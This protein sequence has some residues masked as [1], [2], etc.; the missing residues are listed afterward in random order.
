EE[1]PA[2]DPNRY[3]CLELL[4]KSL[5][6][7]YQQTR[8]LS[9]LNEVIQVIDRVEAETPRDADY[10]PILNNFVGYALLARYAQTDHEADLHLAVEK[11]EYALSLCGPNSFYHMQCMYNLG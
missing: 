2:D 3:E 10:L 8:E 6:G 7:Y 9:D 1:T 11:E 5:M 4:G